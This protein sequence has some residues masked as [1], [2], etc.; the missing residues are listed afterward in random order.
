MQHFW[1]L[2]KSPLGKV[3]KS[4][5]LVENKTMPL[6]DL[7]YAEYLNRVYNDIG[8]NFAYTNLK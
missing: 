4:V 7:S 3:Y 2:N 1:W 6:I 5:S 8:V